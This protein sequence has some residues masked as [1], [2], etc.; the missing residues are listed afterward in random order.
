MAPSALVVEKL[1]SLPPITSNAKTKNVLYLAG[2]QPNK[3]IHALAPLFKYLNQLDGST[4]YNLHCTLPAGAYL[5]RVKQ[6][7]EENN[8]ADNL[9]NL[10]PLHP[11]SI[12]SHIQNVHAMIN[13]AQLE[14]FSNNWVEA[15]ASRRV[16]ICRNADYAKDSC[17]DSAVYINLE[18]PRTSASKIIEVFSSPESLNQILTKGTKQLNTMP[19]AIQKFNQYL[20]ITS[21]AF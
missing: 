16:L 11:D 15:W 1:E 3:N 6:T 19:T 9:V 17:K 5:E 12:P 20:K 14:S 18:D 7:F 4:F 10:G 2:S 21:E 13:V 8:I